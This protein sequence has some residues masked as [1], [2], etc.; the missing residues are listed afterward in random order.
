MTVF[1][2]DF[3]SLTPADCVWRFSSVWIFFLNALNFSVVDGIRLQQHRHKTKNAKAK[4]E[5]KK[6]PKLC[7]NGF[8]M[9]AFLIESD[10]FS[11]LLL[12]MFHLLSS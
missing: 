5:Q 9:A 8:Y 12:F 2:V 6:E 1:S 10:F 11:L 3:S 7:M 4:I